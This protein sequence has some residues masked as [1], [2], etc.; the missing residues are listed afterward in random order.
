MNELKESYQKTVAP[1]LQSEFG[2]KNVHEVPSI[3]KV[4]VNI[5]IGKYYNTVSKDFKP[6]AENLALITGQ[7]ASVRLARKSV[8]NFKLRELTPNGLT[9]TLRGK[10][11][12]DFLNKLVN[13]VLPRVR[14]FRGI[15]PRAFDKGGNYSLGMREHTVFPES[16]LEDEV[17]PFSLQISIITKAQK[18]EHAVSLLRALGFPFSTK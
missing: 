10:R 14:D 9:V 5:G 11:M 15:S 1:K 17:K 8:S 16:K 12:W 18:K 6:M 2:L 4:V 3:K 13:V 7:K